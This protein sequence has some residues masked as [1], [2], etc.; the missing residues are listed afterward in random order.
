MWY[1]KEAKI[2]KLEREL[3]KVREEVYTKQYQITALQSE[4]DR[5]RVAHAALE[6][7]R[8]RTIEE[9]LAEQRRIRKEITDRKALKC[10]VERNQ[11]DLEKENN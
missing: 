2:D 9:Q 3:A 5:Y 4:R 7:N 1:R 8:P 10:L 6:K 11:K